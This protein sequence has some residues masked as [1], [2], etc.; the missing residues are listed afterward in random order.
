[1]ESLVRKRRKILSL[2]LLGV[3]LP[4]IGLGYLALR[5]VRNE[6]ALLEQ[7]GLAGYRVLAARLTD[8]LMAVVQAVE[9]DVAAAHAAG[10]AGAAALD[11]LTGT[12]PL[13]E[14]SF[15]LDGT[16][17]IHLPHAHLLYVA[18][19]S[20]PAPNHPWPERAAGY[21]RAARQ[22]EF[23]RRAST[24]ALAGYREALL[25]ASEPEQRGE[26]LLAMER[27]QRKAGQLGAALAS[28]DL[29]AADYAQVRT[30]TG[31]PLGPVAH[32]ERGSLLRTM[33]DADG[34][35]GELVELHRLLVAGR[36]RLE[37]GEYDFLAGQARDSIE[38]A[39]GRAAPGPIADS[40]RAVVEEIGREEVTRVRRTERLLRFQ[41]V[42]PGPLANRVGPV[43]AGAPLPGLRLSLEDGGETFLLSVPTQSAGPDGALGLLLDTRALTALLEGTL[44]AIADPIRTDWVLKGRDGRTLPGGAAPPPGPA[45]LTATFPGNFPPW[46]LELRQRP[47]S[48]MRVLFASSRSLYSYM[49][50][51][52]ATILVFGL[53]LTARAVTQELEL[54][55]LKSDFLSSVSHE[56]RSPLTSIRHMA[57]MLQADSVPSEERRRRYYDVLVEQSTRLST[58][59]TNI[60]DLARLEEGRQEFRF[61]A[62]DPRA[63]VEDAVEEARHRVQHEGFFVTLHLEEPLPAV[64]GD[65]LTLSQALSNLLDNAARYSGDS[66]TIDV[67]ASADG[68]HVTVAVV[69]QGIG[70][71]EDDLG[72]VFDRFFRGGSSLTRSVKGSG[73]GL[74]LVHEI[75]Q[76]HG[77]TVHVDSE[78]GRGSTFSVRL[79]I[80]TE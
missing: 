44:R 61:E 77:G 22:A 60:L 7:Q 15:L 26:A 31:L 29:L 43:V 78:V 10:S 12:A 17:A 37:H 41:Q 25:A 36:W 40:L 39:L 76:A 42:A 4:S 52:I 14:A 65:R 16:G 20:L 57:E 56:F 68:T 66:R 75:V 19:G 70:I 24:Q 21:M 54:A 6:M 9:D 23:T 11:D 35:L 30:T 58:L 80:M 46:L 48:P 47:M 1:M 28:C 33:G 71:A 50:L 64:R 3:G 69:D 2:F 59:V 79:P 67:R 38:S 27:V 49:L 13:M 74:A 45:T 18:D 8:T 73:L 72:K 51:L 32:L 34:S 62:L 55:R 53:V 5:G 63:L